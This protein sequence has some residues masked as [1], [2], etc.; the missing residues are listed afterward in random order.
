MDDAPEILKDDIIV[1]TT[2]DGTTPLRVPIL[3]FSPSGH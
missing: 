2:A 1:E 3:R